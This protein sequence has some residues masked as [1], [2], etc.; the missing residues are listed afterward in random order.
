MDKKLIAN[1]IDK[2]LRKNKFS[3]LYKPSI[4]GYDNGLDHLTLRGLTVLESDIEECTEYVDSFRFSATGEMSFFD[5]ASKITTRADVKFG[6]VA[7]MKEIDQR[8]FVESLIVDQLHTT[9]ELKSA[10]N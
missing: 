1:E 3:K 8:P 4:D 5:P 10:T 9:S 6:G 2:C 7:L